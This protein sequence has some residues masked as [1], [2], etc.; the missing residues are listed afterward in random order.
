[1]FGLHVT[2]TTQP[3]QQQRSVVKGD[4]HEKHKQDEDGVHWVRRVQKHKRRFM[5]CELDKSIS[6]DSLLASSGS[7]SG[8]AYEE[9]WKLPLN[10]PMEKKE[11]I[12]SEWQK[13]THQEDTTTAAAYFLTDI[14]LTSDNRGNEEEETQEVRSE[15]KIDDSSPRSASAGRSTSTVFSQALPNSDATSHWVKQQLNILQEEDGEEEEDGN[16]D[17]G[18]LD[19]STQGHEEDEAD[20]DSS[21]SSSMFD[22]SEEEEEEDQTEKEPEMDSSVPHN[23]TSQSAKTS[24]HMFKGAE[25]V[26][27]SEGHDTITAL[28]H[29]LEEVVQRYCAAFRQLKKEEAKPKSEKKSKGK[30]KIYGSDPSSAPMVQINS[31]QFEQLAKVQE[32]AARLFVE[33]EHT[34]KA[35]V[36]RTVASSS[37]LFVSLLMP[38]ILVLICYIERGHSREWNEAFQRMLWKSTSEGLLARDSMLTTNSS[39]DDQAIALS[40]R[41]TNLR[42]KPRQGIT[43]AS[44]R[45]NQ[46][47]M[48]T[49]RRLFR[50][51][52][53]LKDLAEDFNHAA[54]TYGAIIIEEAFIPY[55]KKTIRPIAVGGYA[56]G[57]KYVYSGMLFKFATDTHNLYGGDEWAM[58]AAGH[59]LKGVINFYKFHHWGLSTPMMSVIDHRGFRLLAMSLLPIAN[60][61]LVYGSSNSGRTVQDSNPQVRR[62]MAAA[63]KK[64]N[65]KRHTAGVLTSTAKPLWGPCD[66]EGHIG[67]D[68]RF[69]VIDLARA[70]PPETPDPMVPRGHLYRLLRPEFVAN[71]PLPLSSDAFSGFGASHEKERK[72][73][74]QEV[75]D[76]TDYLY[77]VLVPK[78]AR[79]LDKQFAPSPYDANKKQKGKMK[80]R[81]SNKTESYSD[82]FMALQ[83]EEMNEAQQKAKEATGIASTSGAKDTSPF[84]DMEDEDWTVFTRETRTHLPTMRVEDMVLIQHAHR[85]GINAR[86]LGMVRHHA[87]N[88]TAKAL[89][90]TEMVCRVVKN[91]LRA[92]LR[93]EMQLR[94]TMA[95]QPYKRVTL[96]LFNLVLGVPQESSQQWWSVQL[97]QE[98]IKR[99]KGG[100]TEREQHSAVDLREQGL[101]LPRQQFFSMLQRITGV[102]LSSEALQD[103]SSGT[104]SAFVSADISKQTI[105]IKDM[106]IISTAEA[107]TLAMRCLDPEA[108]L[109]PR[110]ADRLLRLAIGKFEKAIQSNPG[111]TAFINYYAGVLHQRARA[112]P[113]FPPMNA[114]MER[115]HHQHVKPTNG[116]SLLHR[117]SMQSA[118]KQQD[119]QK[120]SRSAEVAQI[121]ESE[122]QRLKNRREQKEENLRWKFHLFSK[123]IKNYKTSNN[124]AMLVLLAGELSKL[125]SWII[126]LESIEASSQGQR[127]SQL[128]GSHPTLQSQISASIANVSFSLVF[129]AFYLAH[130]CYQHLSEMALKE[131]VFESSLSPS[132]PTPAAGST[133]NDKTPPSRKRQERRSSAAMKKFFVFYKWGELFFEHANVLERANNNEIDQFFHRTHGGAAPALI[134]EISEAVN[135]QRFSQNLKRAKRLREMSGKKYRIAF[136][137]LSKLCKPLSQL[138]SV[139]H[140]GASAEKIVVDDHQPFYL[141]TDGESSELATAR[142]ILANKGWTQEEFANDESG[143]EA[144]SL[145]MDLYHQQKALTDRVEEG[146]DEDENT[147]S[148]R[149]Q[150]ASTA[151]PLYFVRHQLSRFTELKDEWTN[152]APSS[153]LLTDDVFLRIVKRCR[154]RHLSLSLKQPNSNYSSLLLTQDQTQ[155]VQIS[156]SNS[157]L[158]INFLN[159]LRA[160]KTK[161]PLS[162]PSSADSIATTNLST[163]SSS[164]SLSPSS[165][166][167]SLPTCG[168]SVDALISA[169]ASRCLN[170]L[171]C[172]IL[173]SY[174]HLSDQ[175]LLRILGEDVLASPTPS[176]SHTGKA[177]TP[178]S[179]FSS[180]RNQP[181]APPSPR[182]VSPPKSPR[183]AGGSGTVP[184]VMPRLTHLELNACKTLTDATLFFLA[185]S[186][187]AANLAYLSLVK[188]VGIT[189]KGLDTLAKSCP[190]L[191]TLL[192]DGCAFIT[193]LSIYAVAQGCKGLRTLSL[194][195]CTLLTDHSITELA[196]FCNKLQT[197]RISSERITDISLKTIATLSHIK[198]LGLVSSTISDSGISAL[199]EGCDNLTTLTLINCT[200]LT[201][202]SIECLATCP[203]LQHLTL[204]GMPNIPQR[205]LRAIKARDDLR[206]YHRGHRSHQRTPEQRD[207]AI[208]EHQC[209]SVIGNGFNSLLSLRTESLW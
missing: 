207:L 192:L 44:L 102:K 148:I 49:T 30:R 112:I 176:T 98:L 143:N 94:K 113:L 104:V 36:Q 115:R 203:S 83:K 82:I 109:P 50:R 125:P 131:D 63:A 56:G 42:P 26:K 51:Y 78:F 12:T 202:T 140:N 100:L 60:S 204:K 160:F 180:P 154:L 2:E 95:E 135:C 4:K 116:E 111:D 23:N 18:E 209:S 200:R 137:I 54:K 193:D 89:L 120:K 159:K 81:Y 151:I 67:L 86:L 79:W 181:S 15:N 57:D 182:S 121:L 163:T 171:T 122:R 187:F 205:V 47:T 80:L 11:Q 185:S 7:S 90:L 128:L 144:L 39:G 155:N 198:E 84:E 99:F 34:K 149:A 136:G 53:A 150:N 69:Y 108:P 3:L 170:N 164:A 206:H 127:L 52:K 59:E 114:S 157:K 46:G 166:L 93:E 139:H 19:L 45:R 158:Q 25:N 167:A 168:I 70:F 13:R 76:A 169:A 141:H 10:L 48:G 92:Q 28:N 138:L 75:S 88:P 152:Q 6:S 117:P 142:A 123:A 29:D 9:E 103:L 190:N 65:L 5:F 101:L 31:A 8:E 43:A 153:E 186:S 71:Y 129:H 188:C 41:P 199:A 85:R 173:D 177:A 174:Q 132:P 91:L 17:D 183:H 147:F 118:S 184:T 191:E 162:S 14:D 145:V 172:L 87:R 133:T 208:D 24:S 68:G 37:G 195:S 62:L 73:N 156:A 106:N 72:E 64:L 124:Q 20:L 74:E 35:Q 178:R 196:T 97:K 197:L 179:L 189:D 38:L 1:M 61:T 77:S 22:S 21:E 32:L 66:M 130:E 110:E 96:R 146:E 175:Q 107:I 55:E 134:N 16:S 58:K 27:H 33:L 119:E 105:R 161:P 194:S 40:F 201:E 126:D 165:S